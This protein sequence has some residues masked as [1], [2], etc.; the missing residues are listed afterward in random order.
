MAGPRARAAATPGASSRVC[1]TSGRGAQPAAPWSSRRAAC[2]LPPP[3]A[4]RDAPEEATAAAA[5]ASPLQQLA[6][7]FAGGAL[8][9]ALVVSSP[10]G[11]QLTREEDATIA[12]FNRATPSVVFLQNLSTRRDA[13]TMNTL[14]AP[15]SAGSGFVY[16]V[17]ARSG[18]AT[19]VTNQ[20]VIRG[21]SE[22]RVTLAGGV[23]GPA[24]DH[25]YAAVVVGSDEDRD[26]AV[27]KVFPDGRDVFAP[28][29]LG[30]SDGL[31]VGQRVLAIGNPFGLDHTLTAGVVSG[32][33]REI[34]SGNTG[35]PISNVIQTDAAINPGNS[36]GPLLDS[37]GRV[38][39]IN[40]AIY[41]PSGGSNGV[42]FAIPID[43]VRSSVE[44]VR[45]VSRRP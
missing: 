14:E 18:E 20:H 34:S 31:R 45:V 26:V 4:L 6:A 21:A 22:V 11:T 5:A 33:G 43:G 15:Q 2:R 13:F 42:G 32:I 24:G 39:G 1:S 29:A 16:A 17:D 19:V 25:D 30:R 9:A 3:R 10:L 23:A 27:L 8:A 28:L 37:R 12:L 40:T 44:Q 36:G 35:R 38:V 7:A 41:S